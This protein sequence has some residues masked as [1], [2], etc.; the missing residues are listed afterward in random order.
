VSFRGGCLLCFGYAGLRVRFFAAFAFAFFAADLFALSILFA[1]TC[2]A[3]VTLFDFV[4]MPDSSSVPCQRGC[5]A[6]L[7]T[8]MRA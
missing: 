4:A 6:T 8:G 1:P 2:F 3:L 7:V 5:T